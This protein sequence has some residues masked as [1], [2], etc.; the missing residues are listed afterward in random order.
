MASVRTPAPLEDVPKPVASH[1]LENVRVVFGA[2]VLK[3]YRHHGIPLWEADAVTSFPVRFIFE[4]RPQSCVMRCGSGRSQT[5][6]CRLIEV[7]LENLGWLAQPVFP[8]VGSNVFLV[9]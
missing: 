8:Q 2:G 5:R 6:L 1:G 9:L 7:D 4:L 3:F